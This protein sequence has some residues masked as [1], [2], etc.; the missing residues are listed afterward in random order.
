MNDIE[1][2]KVRE[3]A[4]AAL[5]N[6]NGIDLATYNAIR[7]LMG[8]HG[9]DINRRVDAADG[10]F[11]LPTDHPLAARYFVVIDSSILWDGF[12]YDDAAAFLKDLNNPDACIMSRKEFTEI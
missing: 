8:S 7:D 12:D 11:Y 6:D 3:A 1:I 4:I 2:E 9:D 5:D 10:I